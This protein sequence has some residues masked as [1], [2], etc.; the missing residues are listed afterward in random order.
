MNWWLLVAYRV[1]I[2]VIGALRIRL[3]LNQFLLRA[4]VGLGMHNVLQTLFWLRNILSVG[5]RLLTFISLNIAIYVWVRDR[6]FFDVNLLLHFQILRILTNLLLGILWFLSIPK[7]VLKAKSLCIR[8][9]LSYHISR[10][11]GQS[12][13]YFVKIIIVMLKL[14]AQIDWDRSV[15]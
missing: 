9:L 12:S 8:L 7:L 1:D 15:I 13:L 10:I 6:S 11:W 5:C 14:H 4:Y 2:E 3:I